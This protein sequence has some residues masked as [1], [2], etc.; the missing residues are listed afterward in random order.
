[1]MSN[2]AA[3]PSKF[4]KVRLGAPAIAA[5]R[6]VVITL[7]VRLS[8]RIAAAFCDVPR[9]PCPL[10]LSGFRSKADDE[11]VHG[12]RRRA[13]AP[14]LAAAIAQLRGRASPV[15]ARPATPSPNPSLTAR[16]TAPQPLIPALTRRAARRRSAH[17]TSASSADRGRQ[18]LLGGSRTTRWTTCELSP[19][20]PRRWRRRP[21]CVGTGRDAA[22]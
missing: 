11:S 2:I 1:M 12:R 10:A 5:H 14:F 4:R 22:Q 8:N 3:Q 21:P 13:E 7:Q 20:R 6:H 19:R 15:A 17:P 16:P 18:Q 9:C